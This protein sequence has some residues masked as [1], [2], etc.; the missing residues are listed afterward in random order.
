MTV[1]I[2]GDAGQRKTP[3]GT[4]IG[5]FMVVITAHSP[6]Q[7][8]FDIQSQGDVTFWMGKLNNISIEASCVPTADAASGADKTASTSSAD[9]S[10]PSQPGGEAKKK[11]TTFISPLLTNRYRKYELLLEADRQAKRAE[12]KLE[13]AENPDKG[14]GE[15]ASGDDSKA[16]PQ[17]KESSG[18][19]SSGKDSAGKETASREKGDA[20]GRADSGKSGG[21]NDDRASRYL[22]YN[23]RPR[24]A[25]PQKQP[26]RQ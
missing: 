17:A 18:K 20:N 12:A 15:A 26:W 2:A 8:G 22:L 16:A 21:G 13:V 1:T 7:S 6:V 25:C 23:G 11:L 24:R 14:S 9:T 3:D 5:E 19:E 4:T 10:S